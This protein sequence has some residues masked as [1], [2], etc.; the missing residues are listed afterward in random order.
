MLFGSGIAQQQYP[1]INNFS[2]T[3]LNNGTVHLSYTISE[4]VFTV[5]GCDLQRSDSANFGFVS[6]NYNPSAFGGLTSYDYFY[7]DYPPDP[8]KKY[9]YRVVLGNGTQSNT[10]IVNMAD[11]FGNYKIKHHPITDDGSSYLEFSYRYG[12][13]WILEI[14]DPRGFF[15]YRFGGIAQGSVPLN[16][17]LFPGSGIYFFRLYTYDGSTVIPGRMVVLKPNG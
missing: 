15:M 4:S 13:Q 6:I 2:G 14:V 12:Q 8:T 1:S 7:D 5:S 3:V 11:V 10:I 16:A 17:S 9:Y